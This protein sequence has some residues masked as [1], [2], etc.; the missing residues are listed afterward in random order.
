MPLRYCYTFREIYCVKGVAGG[1]GTLGLER[2][3]LRY[4]VIV[5]LLANSIALLLHFFGGPECPGKME[6]AKTVLRGNPAG[7][8]APFG[9]AALGISTLSRQ[10]GG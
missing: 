10:R 6:T 7:S 4:C 8:I 5:T 1:P 3:S 9:R 2:G